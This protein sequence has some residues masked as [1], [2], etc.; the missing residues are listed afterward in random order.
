MWLSIQSLHPVPSQ[1]HQLATPVAGLLQTSTES[2]M[3]II[4]MLST[5]TDYDMPECFLP[6]QLEYDFS[7]AMLSS[8]MN[9]I[10]PSYV[11]DTSWYRSVYVI[12]DQMISKKNLVAR[13]RKTELQ[14]LDA[15]LLSLRAQTSATIE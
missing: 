9:A 3:A 14:E 2:A 4:L 10:L 5:L 1:E 13:L 7:A 8:L 11:S 12:L 15:R 6:F